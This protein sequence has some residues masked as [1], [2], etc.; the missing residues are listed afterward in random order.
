MIGSIAG[1]LTYL[2]WGYKQFKVSMEFVSLIDKIVDLQAL[3]SIQI[4]IDVGT[5]FASLTC[6]MVRYNTSI[7][8]IFDVP[9]IRYQNRY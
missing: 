1:V 2:V 8:C 5:L 6:L 4:C 7:L 3:I 9:M